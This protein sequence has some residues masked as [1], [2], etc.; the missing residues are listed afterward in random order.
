MEG[1]KYCKEVN[2]ETDRDSL[3]LEKEALLEGGARGLYLNGYV[4]L[5]V[6][7]KMGYYSILQRE[8][9]NYCPMCGKKVHP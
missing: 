1:C 8:V 3:I 7:Y 9:V 2:I 6:E 4:L 5:L